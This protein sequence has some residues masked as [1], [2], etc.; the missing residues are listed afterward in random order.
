MKKI[1]YFIL[2]A[3]IMTACGD[4]DK[5]NQNPDTPQTVTPAF[6]A[7]DLILES[8]SSSISKWF[9]SDS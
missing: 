4:F 7:T 2:S 8:T 9:L 1:F 5:I 6:L 3:I